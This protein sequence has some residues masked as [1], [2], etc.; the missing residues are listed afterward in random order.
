M[1]SGS[2]SAIG[3]RDGA[4]TGPGRCQDTSHGTITLLKAFL[5]AENRRALMY[6]L[7]PCVATHLFR[8]S[9]RLRER[10]HMGATI[11]FRVLER[12]NSEHPWR[13][14]NENKRSICRMDA[15]EVYPR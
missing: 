5:R 12:D 11:V 7:W 1:A 9:T 4:A 14:G 15:S 2:R 6:A 10:S 3:H 8:I 13:W